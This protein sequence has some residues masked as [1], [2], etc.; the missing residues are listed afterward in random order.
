[1]RNQSDVLIIGAGIIGLACAEHFARMG[2]R[3]T[4]LERH[5][6]GAGQTTRT[7]GGIRL[8]HGSEL[9]IRLTL[10]S[11]PAWACFSKAFGVDPNYRETGHL[12][13]TSENKQIDGF[14]TQIALHRQMGVRSAIIDRSQVVERWPQ[15]EKVSAT[16]ALSC[17]QGGYLDHHRVVDGYTR[18]ILSA[19]VR[20]ELGCRVENI[21][22]EAGRVVG[23][24]TSLGAF[25]AQVVINAAGPLAG[26]FTA[27]V[28][29]RD[30]FVSR[31]HELL[32]VAP[33]APVKDTTPWIIDVD[34]QVHLR[35]DGGGRAL[36]GGFLGSDEAS[37][38][39]RYDRDYTDAW[40]DQVRNVANTSFGVTET[41]CPIVTG[42]AGL[43]PGTRD[44]LP[45]AEV[46]VPGMITIAGLSGTGL[47]HAP[48]MAEI[49]WDLAHAS[50]TS[51][52]DTKTLSSERFETTERQLERTGF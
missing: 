23:V 39:Q 10:R 22:Q 5:L 47:M 33:T 30:P 8:A 38:P 25:K 21:V 27:Q 20:L 1:M 32:I 19:G 18:K 31:R 26:R 35:P 17:R 42:W 45:V 11:L 28:G 29:G 4:I 12:F 37:G 46:T 2:S 41:D 9:N 3:V 34:R 15:L 44:Y 49:A 43:Y 36:V 16:H 48:A 40:A 52:I 13:L 51:W 6:P 50:N 24:E 14:R 7:G